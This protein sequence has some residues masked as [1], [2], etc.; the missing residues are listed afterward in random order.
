MA[1]L[2][3]VRVRQEWLDN[4]IDEHGGMSA[5]AEKLDCTTSTISR[6]ANGS[7]EAGPRFIGSVLNAFPIDFDDAFDVTEEE[8]RV[9]RAR[10][11]KTPAA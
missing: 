2:H 10:W 5:L 6:H 3:T 11:V 9:R 1:V 4:A 8:A 7:A